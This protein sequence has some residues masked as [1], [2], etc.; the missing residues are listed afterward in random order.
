MLF[1]SAR[2]VADAARSLARV[3]A[4]WDRKQLPDDFATRETGYPFSMDLEEQVARMQAW[5]EQ[6]E[7]ERSKA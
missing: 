4:Y 2:L 7:G 6:L 3:S 5:A 1:R